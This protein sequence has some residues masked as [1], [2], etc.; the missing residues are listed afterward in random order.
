VV[1]GLANALMVVILSPCFRCV[2]TIIVATLI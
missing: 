1:C 2:V